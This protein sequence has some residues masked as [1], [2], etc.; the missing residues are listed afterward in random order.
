MVIVSCKM[1]CL[2]MRYIVIDYLNYCL[3][4]NGYIWIYCLFFLDFLFKIYIIMWDKGDEFE[5]LYK[6]QFQDLVDQ[7]Y[8]IY[9]MC[10][11]MFKVVVEELF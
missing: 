8:V 2:G 7:L 3:L 11:F 10:Y 1:D 5:E 6:V 4:K 9:D